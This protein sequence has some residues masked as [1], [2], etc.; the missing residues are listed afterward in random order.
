[1]TRETS[2]GRIQ[3]RIHPGGQDQPACG[4]LVGARAQRHQ[5]L[6]IAS[7]GQIASDQQNSADTQPLPCQF[8]AP[9]EVG[10]GIGL[11]IAQTDGRQLFR[12]DLHGDA[13]GRR[14]ETLAQLIL[15]RPPR[16]RVGQRAEQHQRN[17]RGQ[18]RGHQHFGEESC[19]RWPGEHP[20]Q[21]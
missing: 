1:V 16:H 7:A 2:T 8:D 13:R 10:V 21:V 18:Q 3:A 15:Q 5:P 9:G 6:G 19:F 20:G 14:G 11:L 4:Q 12:Q 17:Q